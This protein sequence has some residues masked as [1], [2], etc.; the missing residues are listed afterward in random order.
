MSNYNILWI[1]DEHEKLGGLKMQASQNGITL[2]GHKSL[3]SGLTELESKYYLYDAVLLDAK[4]FENEDDA[5][6]SEDI[7][8][9]ALAK[10]RIQG[11][12][13][14]FDFFVL[15]GQAQLYDDHTF[16]AFVP[17][18]FRKGIADD[19]SL[20]FQ[21]IIAASEKQPARQARKV[22]P[23]SFVPFDKGIISARYEHILVEM[24]S[25]YLQED[26]K[27]KNCN[28]QR[29]LL[30]VVFKSMN[31]IPCI[32]NS[33]FDT[34]TGSPNLAWCTRFIE[35]RPTT[36]GNGTTHRLNKTIPQEIK[37]AFRKLK[38]STSKYSH[39]SEN[40]EAKL[41]FLS[42]TFLLMEILTWLPE[43]VDKYYKNYI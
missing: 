35:D 30:E 2:N 27:K 41:P 23:V 6:G 26:Y 39:L 24:I 13:K 4:F 5:A 28:T 16:K 34:N 33:L 10:D 11:L 21:E 42:N 7:V 9:L 12:R 31:H 14:K 32:P 40:E 18:F 3:N 37:L 19:V 25:S 1:D 17:K 38:E 36:D 15:T 43:F 8:N 20:L 29:D 22:F